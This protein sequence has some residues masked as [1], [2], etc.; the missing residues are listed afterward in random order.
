MA[1]KLSL[2]NNRPSYIPPSTT[3]EI[4]LTL[5]IH[6]ANTRTE[7]FLIVLKQTQPD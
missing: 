5:A 6:V 2:L 3:T 1:Y 4:P 7:L